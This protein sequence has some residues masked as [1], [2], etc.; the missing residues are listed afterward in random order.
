MKTYSINA[1]YQDD[2]ACPTPRHFI[3]Q[4]FPL[5]SCTGYM[6]VFVNYLITHVK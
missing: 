1:T 5:L 2:G 4:I 6:S 3:E